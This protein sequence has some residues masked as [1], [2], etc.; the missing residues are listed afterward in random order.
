MGF[1]FSG[2]DLFDLAKST[3]VVLS[4]VLSNVQLLPPD[5]SSDAR[6]DAGVSAGDGPF[7]VSLGGVYIQIKHRPVQ[8]GLRACS[9]LRRQF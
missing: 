8:R 6:N 1:L 5:G 3:Q 9:V 2:R 4:F 7:E